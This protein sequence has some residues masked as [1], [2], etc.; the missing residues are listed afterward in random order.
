MQTLLLSA[1]SHLRTMINKCFEERTISFKNLDAI[2]ASPYLASADEQT[3]LIIDDWDKEILTLYYNLIRQKTQI[4]IIQLFT[5]KDA[6]L[7]PLDIHNVVMVKKPVEKMQ[8]KAAALQLIEKPLAKA[9]RHDKSDITYIDEKLISVS[10]K[11][12]EVKQKILHYGKTNLNIHIQGES[13]TGKEIVAHLLHH[14]HHKDRKIIIE[15][16]SLLN[17]SLMENN[18]FGHIKGAYSGAEYEQEGLVQLANGNTLFLDEVEDLPLETQSKLLRLIEY[19]EYRTLGDSNT[20]QSSFFLLTASNQD[21]QACLKKNQIR[22]DFFHR[23]S[24]FTIK[25][26]PLRER[27][28]DIPYLIRHYE[29]INKLKDDAISF[30]E[31][32]FMYRWPGNVRELFS[33]T[34]RIHLSASYLG[35]TCNELLAN[36]TKQGF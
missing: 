21:M 28:E 36:S 15:N 11:M 19:G 7:P 16:C 12:H 35:C 18:L 2:L 20:R 4:K 17:G 13:G 22:K 32:L 24:D 26:P 33:V 31:P 29:H 34:A 30:Y 27:I 3:I 14:I 23:I 5:A 8:I 6:Y 25:I 9:I 10:E 1:N